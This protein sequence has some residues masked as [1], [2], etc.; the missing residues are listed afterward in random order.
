[1]RLVVNPQST[2]DIEHTDISSAFF[3]PVLPFIYLDTKA[4]EHIHIRDL[5]T[6]VK[7]QSFQIKM[8]TIAQDCCGFLKLGVRNAKFIL[9][10]ASRDVVMRMRVHVRVDAEGHI[11]LDTHLSCE[12]INDFHLLD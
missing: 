3:K 4:F 8:R 10:Q 2:T 9:I 12:C 11:S 6:D 7:M 1:M 5:G